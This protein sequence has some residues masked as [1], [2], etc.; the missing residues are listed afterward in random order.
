MLESLIACGAFDSI[1]RNRAQLWHALDDAIRW[2]A[3]RSE[4]QA[5]PQLGLFAAARGGKTDTTPPPL[6]ACEPWRAEEELR[7][8]VRRSAS[9]S[10]ATRSTAT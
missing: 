10:R 8:D 4:E 6:P 2:A 7:H 3:L 1:E 9:S 5:S